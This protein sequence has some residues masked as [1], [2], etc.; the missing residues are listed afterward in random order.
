[1]N[2]KIYTT[3]EYFE[4]N[5]TWHIEDSSW[6]AKNILKIIKDNKLKP[7]SICEV[8]CGAGEI[9]NQLCLQMPDDVFFT[10]Y[11]ISPKAFEMCEKIKRER[12]HFYL[13][14][15]FED[16]KAFFD[17]VKAID[18]LEHVEDYLGF[19]RKLR[20]KGTYKIFHIPLD[21]SVQAV[22]RGS[23]LLKARRDVGHIHY[24]TKKTAIAALT[25]TG[26]EILDYFYTGC[27]IDLP[28]KSFK[29]LLARI[30]RKF[31]YSLNKDI[32][33]RIMGGYSLL[34]LAK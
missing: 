24:F 20:G 13:K 11:E 34:V 12:I 30:P 9:L 5:P 6:K 28:P 1:M 15:L 18:V 3:D 33:V 14:N 29:S 23:P 31:F 26:Y 22:L 32:T 4:K 17:I 27:S 7:R 2:K 21:L 25:D 10:G 19:L 16:E 8:G